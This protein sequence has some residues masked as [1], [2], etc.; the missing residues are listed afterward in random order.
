MKKILIACALACGC[1]N[2]YRIVK[3]EEAVTDIG[4]GNTRLISI[5][6]DGSWIWRVKP[7]DAVKF[8]LLQIQDR[9]Q[10]I[11]NLQSKL[12]ATQPAK[13]ASR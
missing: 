8:L 5:R 12:A 13:K 2:P 10:Q 6:K 11:N 1:A 3:S 4:D 7:E 9:Q